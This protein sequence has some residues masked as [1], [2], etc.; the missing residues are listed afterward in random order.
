MS[1]LKKTTQTRRMK[2]W[3]I[4]LYY[5]LDIYNVG[6]LHL[7]GNLW[8]TSFLLWADVIWHEMFIDQLFVWFIVIYA[9][10]TGLSSNVCCGRRLK[11]FNIIIYLKNLC[12]LFKIKITI[13][14]LL[15]KA[16]ILNLIMTIYVFEGRKKEVCFSLISVDS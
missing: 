7:L 14:R 6:R 3:N 10:V 8:F 4:L 1:N 2:L 16:L 13:T 12:M 5:F 15:L 11:L 9:C